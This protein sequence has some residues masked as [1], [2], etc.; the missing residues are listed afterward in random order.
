LPVAAAISARGSD[1][2]AL[3]EQGLALS[4]ERLMS[5]SVDLTARALLATDDAEELTL[6]QWRALIVLSESAA[7]LRISDL[8]RRIGASLSSTSRLVSRLRARGV[9]NLRPSNADRRVSLITLTDRGR[10]VVSEVRSARH[11]LILAA[12]KDLDA[13]LDE[14]FEKDLA[15]LADTIGPTMARGG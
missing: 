8:G 2:R 3:S 5:A 4:L 13:T 6:T 1:D 14:A 10:H 12:I 9:V 11:D 15:R 7:S